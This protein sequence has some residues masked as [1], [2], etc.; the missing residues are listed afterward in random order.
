MPSTPLGHFSPRMV[1]N[2]SLSTTFGKLTSVSEVLIS[3]G[4][5][6]IGLVFKDTRV[7]WD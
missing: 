1:S 7:G 4:M 2:S 5:A 3:F 6:V